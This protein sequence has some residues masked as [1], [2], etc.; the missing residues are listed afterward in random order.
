MGLERTMEKSLST[1]YVTD[2]EL[3]V[4]SFSYHISLQIHRVA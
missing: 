1:F 4:A 2:C 3:V